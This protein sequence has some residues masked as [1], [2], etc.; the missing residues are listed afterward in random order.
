MSAKEFVARH[1]K[2]ESD[3]NQAI[4]NLLSDYE[5]DIGMGVDGVDIELLQNRAMGG[6]KTTVLVNTSVKLDMSE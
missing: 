6:D 4:F 1:R 2:L 3:L 5:K